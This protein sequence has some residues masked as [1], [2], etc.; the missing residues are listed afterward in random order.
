MAHLAA[1]IGP[2]VFTIVTIAPD[3]GGL[4]S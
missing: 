4:T 1:P 3:T 2:T